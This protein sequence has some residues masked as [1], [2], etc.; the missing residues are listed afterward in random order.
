[1]IVQ[2]NINRK[3]IKPMMK[4]IFENGKIIEEIDFDKIRENSNN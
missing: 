2:E 4:T 3:N 1:M